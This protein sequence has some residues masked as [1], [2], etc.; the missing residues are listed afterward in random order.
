MVPAFGT[1]LTKQN[2][3]LLANVLKTFFENFEKNDII[4][5]IFLEEIFKKLI[6]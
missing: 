6:K 3:Q 5:K 2:R 1:F 4:T